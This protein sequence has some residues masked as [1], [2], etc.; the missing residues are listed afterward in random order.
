LKED[1][2]KMGSSPKVLVLERW[3]NG[4][5]DVEHHQ[6]TEFRESFRQECERACVLRTHHERRSWAADSA[7]SAVHLLRT[8]ISVLFTAALCLIHLESAAQTARV[9]KP[10]LDWK[11]LRNPILAV[12]DRMLKDASI[13]YRDGWF[14]LYS[15]TRLDEG[16]TRDW[17]SEWQFYRSRDLRN[18][19]PF[20]PRGLQTTKGHPDSPDVSQVAKRFFMVYQSEDPTRDRRLF[21]S[22]STNLR[23]WT[24]GKPLAPTFRPK[25][26]LIDGA[27]AWHDSFFYLAGKAT[28]QFWVSRAKSMD[29][30][31]DEPIQAGAD[32]EWAENFQFLNIDGVWRMVAT[33]R[34]PADWKPRGGGTYTGSHEPYIY[35]MEGPG[36]SLEHWSKWTNRTLLSVPFEKWNTVM[37]ANSAFLCDWRQHD[38]WFYLFYAGSTDDQRFAKRGHGKI[39]VARSR[40]LA[41]WYVAGDGPE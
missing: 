29:G 10:F 22:E 14:W 28:Q 9:K 13:V 7:R 32:G 38:G 15:S 30:P 31:W 21:W 39:G 33:G 1:L 19:V 17:A 5:A 37:H 6:P 12:E 3:V 34:Q 8:S 36:T 16:D 20:R 11:S 27:L 4:S 35:K 24:R 26:R 25:E 18:W 23:D 40:D 41:T 2:V